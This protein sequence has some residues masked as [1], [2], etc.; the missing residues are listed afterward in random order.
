MLCLSSYLISLCGAQGKIRV[1]H[2]CIAYIAKSDN[3]SMEKCVISLDQ[4][5]HV[6]GNVVIIITP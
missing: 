3:G 4:D 2:T 6:C 1:R 5:V